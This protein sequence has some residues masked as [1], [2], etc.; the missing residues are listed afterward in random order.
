MTSIFVLSR[1]QRKT[2]GLV[3]SIS[4][5]IL[6]RKCACG[7]TAGMSGECEACS[8]E[9]RLDLQTKLNLNEPGDI[10]E[11]EADRIADQAMATPPGVGLS[12]APPSIQRLS[13][14]PAGQVDAVPASVDQA[15]ASPGM[16]LES[17]LRQDMEQRFG[18]DFSRVRVH[19]GSAAEQSA[20]DVN[21][22]A[23][24]MGHH[25]VFDSGRFAPKTQEG[26]R[27]IAHELTHVVQQGAAVLTPVALAQGRIDRQ[28]V[29]RPGLEAERGTLPEKPASAARI[30]QRQPKSDANKEPCPR[31]EIRLGPGQPCVPLIWPG[32]KCPIGQVE[33]GGACVPLRLHSPSSGTSPLGASDS[34]K[35]ARVLSMEALR[36]CAYTVTYTNP[37]KVDCDTAFRNANGK[38][39][40]VP[41]CGASLVYDITSVSAIGSKCPKLEGLKV[42]EIVKGDH[43]C[44]PPDFDFKPGSCLI[45][46]GG[47]VTNCTDTLTICG[48][49]S[50]LQGSGC[51]EIVDQEIEVG[52]QLAEVHEITFDLKKSDKDCS[53]EVHRITGE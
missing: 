33:F 15:L 26:R 27:L 40:P 7:G 50:N 2:Q 51:K 35:S 13:G 32:R 43:G 41:L 22:H 20:Q 25:I 38:S 24:T 36:D 19:S 21:A 30:L 49:T 17:T 46:A 42:S 39:S 18:H 29:V 48:P 47:K 44:T 11:Q 23:Y 31:G 37:R 34:G 28:N 16:P 52:G 14:Q 1:S 3:K 5:P 9:N 8:K 6:Q 4:K 12:G 10:Y 45:G 53:G